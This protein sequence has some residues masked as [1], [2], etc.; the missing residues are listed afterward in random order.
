MEFVSL[1]VGKL[2]DYTLMP[3]VRQ[4][5]YVISYNDNVAQ[6]KEQVEQLR[7]ARESLQ[8]RVDTATRNVEEIEG[9]VLKWLSEVDEIA[10][11]IEKFQEYCHKDA[12]CSSRSF[13][14]LCWSY[15]HSRKAKKLAQEVV[16]IKRKKEFAQVSHLGE[17][18]IIEAGSSFTTSSETFESRV[19]ALNRIT[20]ALADPNLNMIGVYGLGGVGKTTLVHEVVKKAKEQS[21]DLKVVIA[22]VKQNPETREIQQQIAEML[23]LELKEQTP[24]VRAT[25]LRQRLEQEKNILVI[26]DDLWKKL[27]LDEIGIPYGKKNKNCKILMTSRNRGVLSDQMN[28]Q[29]NFGLGELAD[30]EAWKLFKEKAALNESLQSAELLSVARDVVQECGGLPIAIVTVAAALK[31]KKIVEWRDV[32]RR[33][34]T[35]LYFDINRPIEVSYENL[36]DDRLKSIFVLAGIITSSS[37]MDLFKYSCGLGLFHDMNKMEEMKDSFETSIR[38]LKDSCLLQDSDNSND[39]FTM[40]DVVRDA[41]ISIASRDLWFFLK[42]NERLGEEWLMDDKLKSCKAIFLDF[43]LIKKL[44]RGLDCPNLTFFHLENNDPS[45]KLPDN[46]FFGIPALK[47]LVLIKMNFEFLPSSINLL[48]NLHTLCL[49]QCV[50]GDIEI[51]GELRSLKI[52]S[53]AGSVIEQLPRE[54]GQLLKLQLLDLSDCS[55]LEFI[56]HGVLSELKMLEMLFIGGKSFDQWSVGHQQSIAS[57][58]ELNYLNQ[59]SS[60]VVHVRDGIM[61]PKEPLFE[62]LQLQRYNINIGDYQYMFGISNISCSL[63]LDLNIGI[64]D[65]ENYF[66]GLLD[67]V[68]ALYLRNFKGAKNVVPD[69][70]ERGLLELKH[71]EVCFNDELQFLVDS[72]SQR[73]LFSKLKVIVVIGCDKMKSLFSF[74]LPTCLPQL[75]RIEICFCDLLEGIVSDDGKVVDVFQFSELH[76]LTLT[77]V[78]ALIGFYYQDKT[79]FIEQPK[80]TQFSDGK[81]TGEIMDNNNL[82]PPVVLFSKKVIFPNLETL[83]IWDADK[84]NKIW[85]WQGQQFDGS[86]F[87]QLKSLN[88]SSC[89]GISELLP[90]NVLEN[91]ENLEVKSCYSLEVIFDLKGAKKEGIHAVVRSSHLRKLILSNLP[92]LKHVWNRDPQEVIDFQ[93][94]SEVEVSNC[95]SLK[96]LFPVSIAKALVKLQE[97]RITNCHELENIVGGKEKGPDVSLSFIFSQVTIL[98]LENLPKL[99]RFYPGTYST[100]WPLLEELYHV[101]VNRELCIFGTGFLETSNQQPLLV[102]KSIPKLRELTL[103]CMAWLE[104]F[105][106][107]DLYMRQ[108]KILRIRLFYDVATVFPYSLIQRMCSLETLIVQHSSF[109]EIF[110]HERVA[111]EETQH[112]SGIHIKILILEELPRLNH[113][114]KERNTLDPILKNLEELHVLK[115]SSLLNLVPSSVVFNH[116][117]ILKVYNCT[118]ILH[119]MTSF[120]AKSLMQLTTMEIKECTMINQIVAENVANDD[121]TDEITFSKLKVLY[122]QYLPR[123]ETFCSMNCIFNFPSLEDVIISKCPMMKIFSKPSPSSPKLQNVKVSHWSAESYWE[124]DLNSTLQKLYTDALFYQLEE[125]SLSEYPELKHIWHSHIPDSSFG[126]L[127]TLTLSNCE[128]FSKVIPLNVLKCLVYLEE[129]KVES[130]YSVEVIFDLKGALDEAR[131][132]ILVM[133]LSRLTLTSLPNLKHIWNRDPQ[134]LVDFP[135]LTYLTLVDVP[136]L[137]PLANDQSIPKIRELTLN[138]MTWLQRCSPYFCLRKLKILIL[139]FFHDVPTIFPYSF[140]QRMS[141]LKTLIIQDGSFEEI[142]FD[143]RVTSQETQN[144]SGIHIKALTLDELPRLKHICKEDNELHAILKNLEELHVLKCSSLLNLVPSSVMFNHLIS[145]EVYNCEGILHLMTSSTA[146]SLSQLTTLEIKECVMIKE[147]VAD[148]VASDEIMFSGLRT[149]KLEDLP[150]LESFCSMNY[151]FN[152]PSLENVIISECPMM[153][154]FSNPAPTSPKLQNVKNSYWSADSYWEGDLNSTVQKL[155]TDL[156]YYQLQHLNLSEYPELKQVWHSQLPNGSFRNLKTLT[157]SNCEWSSKAVPLNV[158]KCLVNLLKLEVDSCESIEVVFDLEGNINK[159]RDN[160]LAMNL[161]RLTLT[162]LPNL[163][164]VWNKDPQGIFDFPK[165]SYFKLVDLPKLEPLSVEKAILNLEELE[166]DNEAIMILLGQFSAEHFINLEHLRLTFF[167]CANTVFP[168]SFLQKMSKLEICVKDGSFEEIFPFEK[169]AIEGSQHGSALQVKNLEL[170]NLQKIRHICKEGHNLDPSLNNLDILYVEECSS[171]L[172]LGHSSITFNLLK[173]LKVKKCEQLLHLMA[174]STAKSLGQLQK[175]EIAK[176]KMIK[177]V[178]DMVSNDEIIDE[179]IT[180]SKLEILKLESLT[181]LESFCSLNCV[182]NFP[183]LENVVI[184]QCPNL[185]TFSKRDPSTPKLQSVKD[186]TIRSP[187]S[188]WEDDLNSTVQK[189]YKRQNVSQSSD[190]SLTH[191]DTKGEN[192]QLIKTDRKQLNGTNRNHQVVDKEDTEIK[193][194]E[195]KEYAEVKLGNNNKNVFQESITSSPESRDT[196]L[197]ICT[198]EDFNLSDPLAPTSQEHLTSEEGGNQKMMEDKNIIEQSTTNYSESGGAYKTKIHEFNTSIHNFDVSSEVHNAIEISNNIVSTVS[199]SKEMQDVDRSSLIFQSSSSTAKTTE[200]PSECPQEEA[201]DLQKDTSEVEMVQVQLPLENTNSVG[202]VNNIPNV[203]LPV[204]VYTQTS[205][206]DTDVDASGASTTDTGDVPRQNKENPQ[207]GKN[208]QSNG[209]THGE[210]ME[211]TIHKSFM[212]IDVG[213]VASAFSRLRLCIIALC[214]SCFVLLGCYFL[215]AYWGFGM[216]LVSISPSFPKGKDTI[217][218]N[219]AEISLLRDAFARYPNLGGPRE[220]SSVRFQRLAYKTL[221]DLLYFLKIENPVTITKEREKVFLVLCNEAIQFGFDKTWV[222]EMRKRVAKDAEV[223]HAQK[224]LV[225]I[226]GK[227]QE[228]RQE[229]EKLNGFLQRQRKK[230]FGFF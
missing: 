198:N 94:L 121:I 107:A 36:E 175:L 193:K 137:E 186:G 222:E 129:L 152:F 209:N 120:T 220:D 111:S 221:A 168:Y 97:L 207:G 138:C 88:I 65:S 35:H 75:E 124:C 131:D 64:N 21:S 83:S 134:G 132:N 31:G 189:L 161:S 85:D 34:Q 103:D 119:I 135:E 172:N 63:R 77:A 216:P 163:K 213:T 115:C 76:T 26:L 230:C 41:T 139:K 229:K 147:I 223:D 33:L 141:T 133:K 52:L 128:W 219:K 3:V 224:R 199:T 113:I 79:T 44:S 145:L 72:V 11:K 89:H 6:L 217:E 100:E 82:D 1:V 210:G 114:C 48:S 182:F 180:F 185:K 192:K 158:L 40:H 116:L 49:H 187:S 171:L 190:L 123:L 136:K 93:C 57:L 91:L 194:E 29:R 156:L 179:I 10:L 140:I 143:G 166:A 15:Q 38:K 92:K 22:L 73:D 20:E 58:D 23:Q 200:L 39:R 81:D 159:E 130:S 106:P 127:N 70:N 55:Q 17:L 154:I 148:K 32:R 174:S 176:C 95:D 108:L 117:K 201:L 42:R 109:E 12:R 25:R 183:S 37:T 165:L 150:R 206:K 71:L 13:P 4:V 170:I 211:G 195:D 164:H 19:S 30:S 7:L 178:V 47:V 202:S 90:F 80:K 184:R 99:T 204:G 218:L 191:V 28:T 122:L 53:I 66:G 14:N 162:S 167:N 96:T 212:D 142:F 226:L 98:E 51:I 144:G 104:R 69:I 5:G 177:V 181:C 155:Y 197:Q 59:L 78:P 188:Y 228:L 9:E 203:D 27:D 61:L 160:V 157:L 18:K 62:K 46:F 45:L 102:E 24:V 126:N 8:N 74:S 68:E 153:K 196:N 214:F 67:S 86:S 149:L 173:I 151:I 2:L 208:G 60:L 43:C 56:P 118:G 50:L 101:H 227:E 125:L 84:L 225:E 215:L 146:K 112:G 105:S 16:D 54:I 110:P 169:H 205:I 87:S